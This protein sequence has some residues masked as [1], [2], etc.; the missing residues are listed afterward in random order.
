MEPTRVFADAIVDTVI[1]ILQRNDDQ[2]LIQP[3]ISRGT[4]D[5]MIE[6]QFVSDQGAWLA[7][8]ELVINL[9]ANPEEAA[10]LAKLESSGRVLGEIVEYSQG[11]IPYKTRED[12]AVNS[13][14]ASAPKGPSWVP[15]LESASQV[16]PYE[17]DAPT[18][19]IKYGPWL[20]CARDPRFFTQPKILFHRLRKKLPRQ[21]IGAI[22]QSGVFNR[23]S[24][25]NLILLPEQPSEM[26]DAA[27]GVFN[28]RLANWWFV[29]RFGKLMEVGGF[30]VA[31]IPLTTSWERQYKTLAAMVQRI[32]MSIKSGRSRKTPLDEEA[33]RRNRV[34]SQ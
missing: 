25:S 3:R 7:D 9:N 13:Y 5:H 2:S 16:Q 20:W 32:E 28:S 18:S 15:L 17:T 24:L 4:K 8:P 34:E 10:L 22:D 27:L 30:K 26:L 29:K 12:G 21:L 1:V 11:I 23:H 6:S 33:R 14:I 31:R 19:F